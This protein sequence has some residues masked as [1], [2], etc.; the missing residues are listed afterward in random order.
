MVESRVDPEHP[1]DR[2]DKFIADLLATAAT[3][4]KVT[5]QHLKNA[6][7]RHIPKTTDGWHFTHDAKALIGIILRKMGCRVRLPP[8]YC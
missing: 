4:P 5:T 2:H 7:I 3:I 8:L 1:G 6:D